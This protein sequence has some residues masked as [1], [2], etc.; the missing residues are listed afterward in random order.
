MATKGWENYL[1]SPIRRVYIPKTN[2]KQRPLG[3]PI[4]E[5]AVIQGVVKTAIEPIWEATF[6]GT[7][8]G[9]RP[10]YSTHD[11]IDM[12]YRNVSQKPKWVLDADIKGCF[13]NIDHSFLL[14]QFDEDSVQRKLIKQWLQAGI[15][16]DMTFH[17]S[18]RGTP[19]G[20]VI[21]PL[22]A[23]MTLDGMENYLK[24]QIGSQYNKTTANRLRVVRYADDFVVIHE[25]KRVIEDCRKELEPWLKIRGL[26]LSEEKT[27]IVHT[28]SGFDF[29]GFNIRQYTKLK[30]S[31]W[32]HFKSQQG[33]KTLIKPS[34]SA[35][36]RHK[37]EMG[38]LIDQMKAVT[39]DE[40]IRTL[41]PKIQGWANYYR[42]VVAS[43]IFKQL[44]HWLW[45]KLRR[46]A[47]RRHPK[48]G[49]IWVM[50]KYFKTLKGRRWRFVGSE[51]LLKKY[52]LV[53]IE[54]H[55]VIKLGK[56]VYDGDELYWAQRL[57]KGYGDI[58]PK[59]AKAL[60][61]QNGK[62]EYCQAPFKNGDL[63]ELHHV[64][65]KSEGGCGKLK[66]LR[67]M[68]KHCH[69]QYHAQYLK[70]RHVERKTDKNLAEP[71][72]KMSDIQAE[73]M[74]IV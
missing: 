11:A 28:F 16:E 14:K 27:R 57:S 52:A 29:L 37:Q 56:S 69:D 64:K 12:I 45:Q 38:A 17:S 61:T 33:Y 43:E 24:R 7:S 15:M 40:L 70:Q 62:C 39:A 63:M 41:N 21:S 3:I 44:D 67:L 36:K 25:Q 19:Q 1:A 71:Y 58:T 30:T 60:R 42:R 59:K 50:D 66:N 18:V 35:I 65:G 53:K 20:G 47:V 23:N 8:Y 5:D 32:K 6:E 73:I 68:H 31:N 10:G 4:K 2:G 55:I 46:W 26:S 48:K 72:R 34:R 22:L 54:R 49:R 51:N 74:G 13:D 9:F